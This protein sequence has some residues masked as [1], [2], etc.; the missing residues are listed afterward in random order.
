MSSNNNRFTT[1]KGLAQYPSIKTPD[2]KF[3]PEGDYKVN[4]VMEDDEKTNS[5]VSKLEAI[6]EDFYGNDDDVKQAISKGRKVVTQDIYEK[7]EEGHIVMKFKQKAIIT[8]KDGSKIPVK[9]RQFDSK[10]KPI[11]VNIG[12]DSVIKVSFTANPYYMPST[13]TCGLSLRLLAVQVISLN[14]FGD[15][16]ASSYGFEEE[17]GYNGEEPEDS[18]KSFEDIDNDAPGDF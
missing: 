14:E 7:D 1:P 2:T 4:L 13:R 8:K 9:I 6:L 5:L 11:D 10:G 18:S 12:R 17:E 3:N 16:S 15:A